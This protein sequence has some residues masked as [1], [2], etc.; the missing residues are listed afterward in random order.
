MKVT[1]AHARSLGRGGYCAQG[2]KVFADKYGL[3]FKEFVRNGIDEEQL[4]ATGDAMALMAVEAARK[5]ANGK[6]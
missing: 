4:L 1:I 6:A 3:D 2:M 5:E